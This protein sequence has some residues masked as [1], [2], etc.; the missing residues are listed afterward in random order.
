MRYLRKFINESNVS[1][2]EVTKVLN[3]YENIT[4]PD[5]TKRDRDDSIYVISEHIGTFL[6]ELQSLKNEMR[7]LT[8]AI[9]DDTDISDELYDKLEVAYEDI[10]NKVDYY[11]EKSELLQEYTTT[12]SRLDELY[13]I[14]FN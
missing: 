14:I 7:K 8:M 11:E 6:K 1:E 4:F 13:K 5:F 10:N 2:N 3:K 9:N 12:K